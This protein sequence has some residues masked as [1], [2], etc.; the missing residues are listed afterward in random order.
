MRRNNKF[1]GG[2]KVLGR[3]DGKWEYLGDTDAKLLLPPKLM[4][5]KLLR[6]KAPHDFGFFYDKA[7][8]ITRWNPSS[9]DASFGTSGFLMCGNIV[10]KEYAAGTAPNSIMRIKGIS[11]NHNNCKLYYVIATLFEL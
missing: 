7:V 9:S 2:N 4:F 10:T 6:P 3:V 11:P 8:I 5:R 1:V